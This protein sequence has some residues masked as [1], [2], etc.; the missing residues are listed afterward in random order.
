M[1]GEPD[2]TGVRVVSRI[3]LAAALVAA[4]ALPAAAAETLVAGKYSGTGDGTRMFMEIS[5]STAE[6]SMAGQ[7]CVGGG[8]GQL[9]Q[10][11]EKHWLIT[12]KGDAQCLVDVTLENGVFTLS[13]RD[14][15][16]CW[17]YGGQACG[18]YG[19]LTKE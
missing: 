7:G 6:V 19:E 14:G 12:M 18:L 9:S 11:A 1:L 5:G 15:G 2:R 3:F 8:T 16:E 17:S 10:V 4:S 13:P